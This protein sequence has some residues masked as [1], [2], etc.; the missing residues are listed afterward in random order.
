MTGTLPWMNCLKEQ[1]AKLDEMKLNMTEAD[2]RGCPPLF[3]N[4]LQQTRKL[5]HKMLPDYSGLRRP[6]AELHKSLLD[7]QYD[8]FRFRLSVVL[9]TVRYTLS[10]RS[11]AQLWWW[12]VRLQRDSHEFSAMLHVRPL[13]PVAH[14]SPWPMAAHAPAAARGPW[15]PVRPLQPAQLQSVRS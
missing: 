10:F 8:R 2:L 12:D 15:Q 3:W 14:G 6:F 9:L 1:Q 4:F 11:G 13:Q 7:S 5:P